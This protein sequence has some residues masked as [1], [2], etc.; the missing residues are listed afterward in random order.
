M[1]ASTLV[2]GVLVL[3]VIVGLGWFR[4][5]MKRKVADRNDRLSAERGAGR[6]LDWLGT[7][8]VLET[9]PQTATA[10]VNTIATKTMS[11]QV[12]PTR[13]ALMTG[14]EEHNASAAFVRTPNGEV[15]LAAVT[16]PDQRGGPDGA[17]WL[18]FRDR[19]AKAA[20]KAEITA[21]Q[22]DT[23]TFTQSVGPDGRPIWTS[24]AQ[25]A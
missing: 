17:A 20:R 22:V 21:R 10:L 18:D 5:A 19:V 4:V 8:L 12:G 7:G 25:P 16:A 15:A 11:K 9:D 3:V 13:W 6:A 23:G 2:V 24:P 14:F 1:P